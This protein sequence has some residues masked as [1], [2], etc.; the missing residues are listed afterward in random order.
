V[1]DRQRVAVVGCGS[2]G[3]AHLES[4]RRAGVEIAAVCDLD[5]DRLA[6]AG[7]EFGVGR[8]FE[9]YEDLLAADRYDLVSVCTM[10]ATH[11]EVAVAALAAGANVL[12]EK[13]PALN[14]AEVAAMIRAAQEAGRFLTFG[15][16]MRYLPNARIL[17]RFVEAGG[18]G[19]PVYTRA[20]TFASDIPWWGKHWVK[21]ISG[22]G[23][24]ASTA[25]HILD[26][27]L[28]MAGDPRPMTASASMT[29]LFPAKRGGTAPDEA[30]AAAFDV[31]DTFSGHIR[32][33]DGSWMTLEGGW[34]Y[35]R[36]DYS[37]SFEMT[38]ERAAIRFDPMQIVSERDGAPVDITSEY[39]APAEQAAA[40]WQGG[41]RGA[42]ND[43]IADVVAAVRDGR[44]PM[45]TARQAL[46]VQ[47]TMDA[48]Y[49]SAEAGLEVAVEIPVAHAAT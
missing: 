2:I 23:V 39:L 29:R 11:R 25:V 18:L 7:D 37:Y 32:F 34:S 19:R 33:E 46:T 40:T 48:L 13:P 36:L 43:E 22:G 17:K 5:R 26:L 3:R 30:S 15:F 20:W 28:W 47:A 9:R 4:Y 1:A 21:S 49:R 10:P 27:A 12:C 44:A 31:E 38:G 45:V 35:D 42:I 8:R 41:W 16:N 6:A 14:A 24:L